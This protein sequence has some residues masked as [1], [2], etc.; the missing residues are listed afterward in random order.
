LRTDI[1]SIFVGF[2]SWLQGDDCNQR[3]RRTTVYG[4]LFVGKSSRKYYN[5][6]RYWHL[7]AKE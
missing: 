3:V 1:T 2:E 4:G 6:R 5:I 7:L